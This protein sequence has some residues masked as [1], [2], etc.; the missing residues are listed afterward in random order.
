MSNDFSKIAFAALYWKMIN[1]PERRPPEPEEG[2][3]GNCGC[4][5]SGIILLLIIICMTSC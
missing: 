1:P 2:D 3:T 5:I 4:I